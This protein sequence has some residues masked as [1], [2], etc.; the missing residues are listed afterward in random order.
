MDLIPPNE[1]HRDQRA[2]GH[3]APSYPAH[4]G[5]Y[6][7][8]E[9]L[10]FR[11]RSD[12]FDYVVSN[13]NGG[14]ATVGSVQTANYDLGNGLRAELGYRFECGWEASFA[15]TYLQAGGIDAV[16]ARPG[17][18][19]LP[20]IS[21]P[22]LIDNVFSASTG[23][24]LNFSLY[25]MMIG[26][27]FRL[28]ENFAYRGFAGL[29]FADVKQSI[30]AGFDG[31]DARTATVSRSSRFRGFG[32]IVGGEGVLS[33]PRGFHAYARATAGLLMGQSNNNFVETN[34]AG[35]TLYVDSQYN[36]W[37]CVPIAS[38]A[39]GGGWQYR[40]ISIRAGYEITHLFGV[41]DPLRFIDDVGQGKLSTRP[42]NLSL[43]GFFVQ[44]GLTF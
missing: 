27:R 5:F 12:S 9:Y 44:I 19:L 11:P 6:G 14:L 36:V 22:G 3:L 29:R 28:D 43:D 15:Y 38:V 35:A 20:T 2:A 4:A 26:K 42:S 40:T 24:N 39:V 32:P 18:V 10:L 41:T 17:Q 8:A 37:K 31:L 30:N 21:R 23:V 7:N 25:D 33:G 34:D 1:V 13:A 16:A